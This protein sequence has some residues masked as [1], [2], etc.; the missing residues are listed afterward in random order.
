VS[1]FTPR[2]IVH[3]TLLSAAAVAIAQGSIFLIKWL[4]TA[5]LVQKPKETK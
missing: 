5:T 4:A 1:D 2:T 3:I